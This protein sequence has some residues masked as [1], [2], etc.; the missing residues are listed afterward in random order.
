MSQFRIERGTNKILYVMNSN[1]NELLTSGLIVDYF[2]LFHHGV[3]PNNLEIRC[4]KNT[5]QTAHFKFELACCCSKKLFSKVWRDLESWSLSMFS[6]RASV[7]KAIKH[8]WGLVLSSRRSSINFANI[9]WSNCAWFHLCIF[10]VT[11]FLPEL[12]ERRF[13]SCVTRECHGFLHRTHLWVVEI[14]V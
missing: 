14:N 6:N 2:V 11:S 9:P 3:W 8:L 12:R 4:F 7:S 5:T 13:Q 1:S 10:V